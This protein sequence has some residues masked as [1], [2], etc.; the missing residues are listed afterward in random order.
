MK[1]VYVIQSH[2]YEAEAGVLCKEVVGS[3]ACVVP[4]G[5]EVASA[6]HLSCDESSVSIFAGSGKEWRNLGFFSGLNF[7]LT[8]VNVEGTACSFVGQTLSTGAFVSPNAFWFGTRKFSLIPPSGYEAY[9]F[10]RILFYRQRDATR[11]VYSASFIRGASCTGPVTG[12][13]YTS[14]NESTFIIPLI[15]KLATISYDANGGVSAPDSQSSVP[16][17]ELTL[18]KDQPTKA[19]NTF[20]GWALTKTATEVEYVPGG[21]Y[22]FDESKTLYAVWSKNSTLL[23]YNANGGVVSTSYKEVSVGD[24]YGSLPTPT[25]SDATFSGWYTA[26]TGGTRVSSSTVVSSSDV[27]V[28][29]AHWDDSYSFTIRFVDPSGANTTVEKTYSSTATNYF[30]S[31]SSLGWG[32]FASGYTFGNRWESVEGG[33]G[34]SFSVGASFTEFYYDTLFASVT[35]NPVTITLNP[36]GGSVTPTSITV[37]PSV[38]YGS[39]PTPVRSGH[40]FKGWYTAA[41]GGVQVTG[42]SVAPSTATTIYAQWNQTEKFI[43]GNYRI[44][45]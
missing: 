28:I 10:I 45:D 19:D 40:T 24:T 14:A 34:A 20:K 12:S 43:I 25:K 38:Q 1:I 8:S 27:T 32:S 2:D 44:K 17:E 5:C 11:P 30:P 29:Y 16:G 23:V 41:T 15:R 39:L 22:K 4:K 18:T 26:A 7:N 36:N 9:G 33:G 31:P 21:K 37:I 35:C 3:V 6:S 42:A 13:A